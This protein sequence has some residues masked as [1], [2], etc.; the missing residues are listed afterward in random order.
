M[1]TEQSMNTLLKNPATFTA[2]TMAS[3]LALAGGWGGFALMSRLFPIDISSTSPMLLA[4][5]GRSGRFMHLAAEEFLTR[6]QP[7]H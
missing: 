4:P 2:C 1:H 7:W 3:V 6:E 5:I